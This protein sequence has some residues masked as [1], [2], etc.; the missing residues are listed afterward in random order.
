MNPLNRRPV[1]S[2]FESARTREELAAA[3]AQ[4]I[5]SPYL[6]I[7]SGRFRPDPTIRIWRDSGSFVEEDNK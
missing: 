6:W 2:P 1:C 3:R 7:I 4:Q 5:I